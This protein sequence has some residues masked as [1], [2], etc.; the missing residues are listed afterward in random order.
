MHFGYYDVRKKSLKT[1]NFL[2]H[3]LGAGP[4]VAK[5]LRHCA[6]S[7]TVVSVGIFSVAPPDGTMCPGVYSAPENEYQ[8][9]LLG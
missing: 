7:Q 9:F 1:G 5:W 8:V 4:V 3:F 6:T 2:T